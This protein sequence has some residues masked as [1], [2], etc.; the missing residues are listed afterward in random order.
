MQNTTC[1]TVCKLIFK[2]QFSILFSEGNGQILMCSCMTFSV[3][4]CLSRLLSRYSATNS[5][6]SW[7]RYFTWILIFVGF[8]LKCRS[9]QGYVCLTY[10]MNFTTEKFLFLVN[11]VAL[12]LQLQLLTS[13]LKRLQCHTN[14]DLYFFV[15]LLGLLGKVMKSLADSEKTS[16]GQKVISGSRCLF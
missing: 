7:K 14:K 10:M 11:R 5:N 13:Q 15:D 3:T 1:H 16:T 6:F 9:N 8:R 2:T 4:F 12:L